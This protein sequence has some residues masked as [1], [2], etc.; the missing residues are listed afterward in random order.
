MSLLKVKKGLFA[1]AAVAMVGAAFGYVAEGAGSA[2]AQTSA[3]NLAGLIAVDNIT[4]GGGFSTDDDLSD[5][6][7]INGLFTPTTAEATGLSQLIAVENTVGD[8]SDSSLSDLLIL[9]SLF[10]V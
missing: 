5:L 4:D 8:G 3:E 6:I 1:L 2:E 10:D 9:N 7:I